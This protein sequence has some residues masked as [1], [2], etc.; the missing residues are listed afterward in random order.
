MV[1]RAYGS[2]TVRSLLD[3]REQCLHN[4]SFTDIYLKVNHTQAVKLHSL[5]C[6]LVFKVKSTT[7]FHIM[8]INSSFSLIWC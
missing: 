4:A 6:A 7:S 1:F 2:L 8:L 5:S 3:M